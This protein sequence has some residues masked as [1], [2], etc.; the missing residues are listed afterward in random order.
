MKFIKS[1]D[2]CE[3]VVDTL[4]LTLQNGSSIEISYAGP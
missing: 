3:E 1:K 4:Q 2:N